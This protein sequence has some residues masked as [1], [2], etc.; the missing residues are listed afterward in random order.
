M[1]KFKEEFTRGPSNF[2]AI[3]MAIDGII[4][5]VKN[6]VP[7]RQRGSSHE[8][9]IPPS[10]NLD[11]NV[12]HNTSARLMDVVIHLLWELSMKGIDE[13]EEPD[14]SIGIDT[15]IRVIEEVPGAESSHLEK[16]G[17]YHLQVYGDREQIEFIDAALQCFTRAMELKSSDLENSDLVGTLGLLAA[18]HGQR[19]NLSRRPEDVDKSIEYGTRAVSLIPED[20]TDLSEILDNLGLAHQQ[21]FKL[22]DCLNDIQMAIEYR[23]R[24]VLLTSEYDGELPSRLVSLGVSHYSRF[25]RT[26]QLDDIE[27]ALSYQT[28]AMSLSK[29]ND[30]MLYQ[31]YE[32]LTTYHRSRFR[33]LEDLEDLNASIKLGELAVEFLPEN[34]PDLPRL[35]ENLGVSYSER[36]NWAGE[37]ED[38]NKAI[39]YQLRGTLLAP[40]EYAGLPAM[41]IDLGSSYDLRHR[42]SGQISDIDKAIEYI[43]NAVSLTPEDHDEYPSRLSGLAIVHNNRFKRLGD[44]SDINQAIQY[45]IRAVSVATIPEAHPDLPGI[46]EV[47][48]TAYHDRFKILGNLEDLDNAIHYTL[49]PISL[50]PDGHPEIAGLLTCLG[51]SHELRFYRLGILE[52]IEKSIEYT[53]RAISITSDNHPDLP[54]MLSNLGASY[55]ARFRRLG[56]L[57][58]IN[59]AIENNARAVLLIPNG[60]SDLPKV[61][62]NLGLSYEARF[63]RLGSLD[64]IDEGVKHSTRALS[65]TPADHA[66]RQKRLDILA[67][68]HE[69]RF[70]RLQ[71]LYDINKAVEYRQDA[72]TLTPESHAGLP[73]ALDNLGTSLDLRFQHLKRLDDI[74]KA[75]E[76]KV[77]AVALTPKGHTDLRSRHSSLGSSYGTRFGHLQDLDDIEKAIEH[78]A[79]GAALAPEGHADLPRMFSNL[80]V[81]YYSRFKC[82]EEVQDIENAI[83]YENKAIS[84]MPEGHLDLPLVL[85]N[86]GSAYRERFFA[87][88]DPES[89]TVS[90]ECFRKA[91]KSLAGNPREKFYS[92]RSW[93]ALCSQFAPS[94]LL[95]VY[96]IIMNLIPQMIW[97]GDPVAQRYSDLQQMSDLAAEAAAVAINHQNYDL[98]LEW[99]E[100]ARS[101]VWN[102]SLQLQN[103]LDDLHLAHPELADNIRSIAKEL[104]S[105]TIERND[106]VSYVTP[107]GAHTPTLEEATQRHRRLAEQYELSI[108]K[109]RQLAGFENFL[110]PSTA[111]KLLGAA[112][113]GPVIVI[114]CH[115]CRCDA[116][117]V[118]PEWNSVTHIPLPSL[119][120]EKA[121]NS[122]IQ[123]ERLLELFGVRERASGGPRRPLIEEQDSD[124]ELKEE[125]GRVIDMLWTDI[126]RPVLEFFGY[127]TPQLPVERLPHITWCMAGVLSFLPLHAAASIESSLKLMDFAI[128][129]YTPT[130]GSL[131][132]SRGAL[133]RKLSSTN[134]SPSIVAIGQPNTPGHSSLPGTM[135]EL[136]HIEHHARGLP[137]FTK[138]VNHEATRTTVLD[139]MEK[140]EWVH[141]ACHAHQNI[142]DPTESGFFLHDGVLAVST[143]GKRSLEN[144]GLAFLSACQTATGDKNLPD[145]AIHLAAGMLMAGYPS[146]I[147]TM[148]SVMDADAPFVAD[149]V[150]CQLLKEEEMG[151]H[152]VARALHGAVAG[153]R[154]EVGDNN[155]TRWAPYIHVG[156]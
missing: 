122:R 71:Q 67:Q 144:K 72:I 30:P 65:L 91:T 150:Y 58:D 4:L 27:K 51:S 124:Y 98:A 66:D 112:R 100:Q 96:E 31:V 121:T 105:A 6:M 45:S 53:A 55:D 83:E 156:I 139:A 7:T 46:L 25:Q 32:R 34:H 49:L 61:L 13:P 143:I 3:E 135:D 10:R 76:H 60:H 94:M 85:G 68:T 145:E 133:S 18:T 138:F 109:V 77:R 125:F 132:S 84:L 29:D 149:R 114:N 130:L 81:S 93:A 119:T 126:A 117:A 11:F 14:A 19:F 142:L 95:E 48:G 79:C 54:F 70:H 123:I 17:L 50:L 92:A 62:D 59:K 140:H 80:G 8:T 22:L 148:W 113:D 115:K 41:L 90:L 99:L 38:I 151:E 1:T 23:T 28:R 75:I 5:R 101:V 56:Q 52:D 134:F 97:L 102:Q 42:F 47:L 86:L 88:N 155:F 127:L 129:S 116:L 136:S 82:L 128:S 120:W 147:G 137:S 40:E 118:V 107:P 103:P 12:A 26:N 131:I 73:R 33:L 35:L 37:M 146:V 89:L 36:F 43:G 153:L 44:L 154:A 64:D 78:Q 110:L 69:S 152:S 24:V 104:H 106:G 141:L 2:R 21:R 16:L 111:S 39:D 9:S 63:R 15:A 57:D 87:L 74:E 20:S 108:S